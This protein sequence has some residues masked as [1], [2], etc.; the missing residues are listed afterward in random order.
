MYWGDRYHYDKDGNYKG[1]TTTES[2]DKQTAVML[3]VVIFSLYGF[4]YSMWEK[5]NHFAFLQAAP[6]KYAVLYYQVVAI[7]PIK[8]GLYFSSLA[9]GFT[10]WQNLNWVISIGILVGYTA[11]LFWLFKKALFD[12]MNMRKRVVIGLWIVLG[13]ALAA[14]SWGILSSVF[15]WLFAT[16]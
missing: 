6:Y 15:S 13:P 2:P 5:T 4:G 12:G 8:L 10:P 1:K 11:T 16:S 9:R 14:L 3:V 7:F